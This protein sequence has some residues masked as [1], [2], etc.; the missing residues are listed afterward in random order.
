[1]S[2]PKYETRMSDT[3]R[4]RYVASKAWH[5]VT[6]YSFI[7]QRA[8]EHPNRVVFI[9]ETRSLTYGE[10]KEQVDRCAAFLKSIGIGAGDVVTMQF[11]NR[12]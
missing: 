2:T 12:V 3:L 10:L 11:P 5:D 7:E 1:M 4:Q 6:F 9:D 8:L